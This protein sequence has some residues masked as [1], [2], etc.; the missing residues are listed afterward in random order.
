[1]WIAALVDKDFAPY[2]MVTRYFKSEIECIV[3]S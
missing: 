1:M 3:L 2:V